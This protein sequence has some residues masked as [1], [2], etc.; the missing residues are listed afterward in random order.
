MWK[1]LG[2]RFGIPVLLCLAGATYLA[3]PYV[4][5]ILTEWFRADVELRAT[6]VAN[7]IEEGLA[8]LLAGRSTA[9]IHA[10]LAKVTADERLLAV[11]VCGAGGRTLYRT[12][13]A[14]SEVGCPETPLKQVTFQVA[15]VA[16]GLV[17]V[18]RFPFAESINNAWGTTLIHDLSFIDRR[19]SRLRDYLIAFA[20]LATLLTVLLSVGVAWLVL[21]VQVAVGCEWVPL[22]VGGGG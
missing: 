15:P 10:Y 22:S 2:L 14:P 17:H 21:V 18:A 9:R 5:R 20:T 12:D 13:L 6:T 7:S 3:V 4:D 11:M 1:A 16:R 8:P 19:Q